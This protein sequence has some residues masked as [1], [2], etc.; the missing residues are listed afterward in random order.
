MVQAFPILGKA[1]AAVEPGDRPFDDPSLGQPV[2]SICMIAFTTAR[3]AMVRLL[4]PF[5]AGGI[6]GRV[7]AIY[8]PKFG[9]DWQAEVALYSSGGTRS[10]GGNSDTANHG[11]SDRRH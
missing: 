7:N 2:L 4:P 9:S 3:S 5:F 11:Y 10:T 8:G 6:R 1:A